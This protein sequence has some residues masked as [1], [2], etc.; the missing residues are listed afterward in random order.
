MSEVH[1]FVHS[2]KAFLAQ[3][4]FGGHNGP[5]CK[6]FAAESLVLNENSVD[7]AAVFH[8]MSTGHL[9]NALMIDKELVGRSIVGFGPRRFAVEVV[10]NAIGNCDSGTAGVIEFMDMVDFIDRNAVLVEVVH[11]SRQI[12][13]ERKENVHADAEVR[14]VEESGLAIVAKLLNLVETV[15]PVLPDTTGT[16]RLKQRR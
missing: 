8:L 6:S 11:Y 7:A 3:H 5:Q 2:V 9:A 16:P 10:D 1:D 15:D 4:P 12:L 13:V 14:A